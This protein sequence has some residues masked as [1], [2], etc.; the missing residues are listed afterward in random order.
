MLLPTRSATRGEDQSQYAAADAEHKAFHNRLAKQCR[1]A[2]S[3]RET[4]RNFAL[5]A[6]RTDQ[7]QPGQVKAGNQQYHGNREKQGAQQGARCCTVR[8]A[9]GRTRALMWRFA[10]MA[11]YPRMISCATRLRIALRPAWARRRA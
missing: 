11:G 3:Q 5:A 10:I 6:N 2:R 1:S 9:S 8:F 7:H 4:H